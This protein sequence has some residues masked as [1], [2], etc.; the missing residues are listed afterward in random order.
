[1]IFLTCTISLIFSIKLYAAAAS[2]PEVG[3]SR[4]NIEGSETKHS[5]TVT[6]LFY[7]PEIPYLKKNLNFIF[8]K[9]LSFKTIPL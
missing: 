1:V 5:P 3:S 2:K 7:P 8:F 4:N 9:I 6:L